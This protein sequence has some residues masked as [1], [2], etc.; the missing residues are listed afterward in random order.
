MA[1]ALQR[2]RQR[3]AQFRFVVRYE[4]ARHLAKECTMR[5]VRAMS[6]PPEAAR[7]GRRSGPSG[8]LFTDVAGLR[9]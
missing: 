8:P 7:V 2:L 4:D 3:P 9:E 6:L 5:P 1:F